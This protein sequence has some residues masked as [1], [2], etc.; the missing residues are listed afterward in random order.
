MDPKLRRGIHT[1]EKT[2][3]R[4]RELMVTSREHLKEEKVPEGELCRTCTQKWQVN[5][6]ANEGDWGKFRV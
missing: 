5:S 1:E 6:K 2:W 3:N 4:Q